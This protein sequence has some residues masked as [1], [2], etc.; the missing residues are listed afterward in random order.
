MKTILVNEKHE[1]D[2][3]Q[4]ESGSLIISVLCGSIGLYDVRIRLNDEELA[5]YEDEGETF[6]TRFATTIRKEESSFKGRMI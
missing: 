6:L 1:Y 5:Q 2:L 4:D 3:L